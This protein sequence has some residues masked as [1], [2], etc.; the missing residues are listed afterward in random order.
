MDLQKEYYD[1]K[2]KELMELDC[3]ERVWI[4]P[5]RGEFWKKGVVVD[6]ARVFTNIKLPRSYIV[7]CKDKQYLRRNRNFYVQGV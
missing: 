6:N 3:G 4:Q 5:E 2:S 7:Q 1:K